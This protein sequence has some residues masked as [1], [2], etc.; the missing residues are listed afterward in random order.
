AFPAL[1]LI[2]TD[3][4]Y[5]QTLSSDAADVPGVNGSFGDV[6]SGP[7]AVAFTPDGKYLLM[8]DANSE[9]VMIV[10]AARRGE[11]SLVRPLPGKMPEG[12]VVSRDG[13]FAYVDERISTDVAILRLDSSSGTLAAT[14]DGPPIVRLAS[15]PMPANLRLG[16]QLFN[17]ANSSEYPLT[18]DH[19][20]ACATCHMEGRSDAVTWKFAQGPRD[21]PTNAGGV[22][23]TGFL[24]RTAD[25]T[26]V[27]D[28]WHTINVEQGG[29]FDPTAQSALLDSL[30][31]YVN[32]ALPA[33]IPPTTDAALVAQGQQVFNAS[34]CPSCHSGP[35]FTDSGSGNPTLDLSGPI[36]LH[37]VGTCVTSG[38]FP[39]V[40][41]QDV[42]GNDRAACAFDTPSLTGIASTP[43]YLH[44]GSAAT[45]SD[46]VQRMPNP[47]ASAS[48]LNALV[49]Y[50]R[51][52]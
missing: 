18:T 10:D 29:R 34:G 48:D 37:D 32:L 30:T 42:D 3:G 13:Q 27:Q 36:L 4:G 49:E 16:Q 39:D 51:S 26:K 38:A 40:A 15:D 6:V 14:V 20:I 33:P 2:H 41:H 21:T 12:I 17:S 31:A 50:L 35:R 8:V 45:I 52:L 11:S 23:G 19:W 47:P 28:Y 24:F 43:P 5:E 44:D 25:R 46:A 7:H 9:D 1:S 22:L